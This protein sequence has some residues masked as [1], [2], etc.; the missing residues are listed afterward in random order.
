MPPASSAVRASKSVG[1]LAFCLVSGLSLGGCQSDDVATGSV[2]IDDYHTRHP[3]VLTDGPT[4]LDVFPAGIGALDA[5]SAA[6]VRDFAHRYAHYGVSRIVILAP[7]GGG[8]KI[9]AGVDA[10]R[11]ALASAGL[12]GTIGL[13]TYPVA[14]PLLAAPIKLSFIGLKAEVPSRC[15]QW[16]DDLASGSSTVGWKN[17][18][19]WNYG[20]ATQSMLAAQVDDPRDFVRASALGPSDVQ[21]RLRAINDVRQGGDP[22]TSWK[23][24]NTSIGQV[25]G[26]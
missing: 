25:G 11:H 22:G 7:A 18:T 4:T 1:L 15:G 3:I 8:P 21:M 6:D 26:N 20:C 9:R 5:G 23:V 17:Q 13:G 16:P 2:G 24:Q 19:Y 10:V 12:H 14:D